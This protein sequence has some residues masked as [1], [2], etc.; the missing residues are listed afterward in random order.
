M[1]S[2]QDERWVKIQRAIRK[3]D[4]SELAH[5]LRQADDLQ[6]RWTAHALAPMLKLPLFK[7]SLLRWRKNTLTLFKP[8]PLGQQ[9]TKPSKNVYLRKWYLLVA[10]ILGRG[11]P[12]SDAVSWQ[13]EQAS[14]LK[15]MIS[16]DVPADFL[17]ARIAD[18]LEPPEGA[19]WRLSFKSVRR[20]NPTTDLRKMLEGAWVTSTTG[21]REL[22]KRIAI[23]KGART[24]RRRRHL[25]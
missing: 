20:G 15:M 4:E 11:R 7:P 18:L 10:P 6:T 25:L 22:K 8:I 3:G 13:V 9:N 2:D 12:K 21:Q 23:G 1:S 24:I 16:D 17:R 14:V 19:K 5:L